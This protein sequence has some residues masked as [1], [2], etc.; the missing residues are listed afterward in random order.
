VNWDHYGSDEGSR[1]EWAKWV[2]QQKRQH[3]KTAVLRT[4]AFVLVM[5]GFGLALKNKPSLGEAFKLA[6]ME[7]LKVRLSLVRFLAL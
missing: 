6:R 7:I 3:V 4:L 2:R 5:L 1:E